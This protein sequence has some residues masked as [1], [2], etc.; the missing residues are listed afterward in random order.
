MLN[1]SLFSMFIVISLA[2]IF[3]LRERVLFMPSQREFRVD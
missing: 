1:L 3:L 2:N